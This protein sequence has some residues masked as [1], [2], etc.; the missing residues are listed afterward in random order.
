MDANPFIHL[1]QEKKDKNLL[2]AILYNRTKEITFLIQANANVNVSNEWGET[3]LILSAK[4]KNIDLENIQL[5]IK[6]NAKVNAASCYGNTALIC[7]T[8]SGR[9]DTVKLLLQSYYIN[10]NAQN[11][12]GNTALI[13]ATIYGHTEIV[14]LLILAGANLI[15]RN[16]DQKTALCYSI[17]YNRE[18]I[19]TLLLCAMTN[20]Q[21]SQ[22]IQFNP[23]LQHHVDK[24][25]QSG[26]TTL[27]TFS[28]SKSPLNDQIK[29]K[30]E[31]AY[32]K[33]N[34]K[35]NIFS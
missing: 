28:F 3:P 35:L 15:L 22:E 14:R 33:K 16:K 9:T 11:S 30:D 27:L 7:A 8:F 18:N 26:I 31:E 21:L 12:R 24:F 10:I 29:D 34:I 5:L 17:D 25:K 6:M 20:E 23:A 13:W 4:S 2:E 32:T 1:T 19:T